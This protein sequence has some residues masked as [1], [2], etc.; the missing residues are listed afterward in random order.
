MI[1]SDS[2][3]S[4]AKPAKNLEQVLELFE[5]A[6]DTDA[7]IADAADYALDR[8][9]E[10]ISMEDARKVFNSLKKDYQPSIRGDAI[11]ILGEVVKRKKGWVDNV[12]PFLQSRA[13]VEYENGDVWLDV[14]YVLKAYLKALIDE[15]QNATVGIIES[16]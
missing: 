10:K 11:N 9:A 2:A 8:A 7:A 14:R 3:I 6:A 16:S 13:V 4:A 12:E 15:E 1:S 5:P